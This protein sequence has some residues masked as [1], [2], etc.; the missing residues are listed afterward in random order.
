MKA[1]ARV[2][3]ELRNTGG[4]GAGAMVE[5]LLSMEAPVSGVAGGAA[6]KARVEK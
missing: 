2:E 6:K 1:G 3:I 5:N 4:V